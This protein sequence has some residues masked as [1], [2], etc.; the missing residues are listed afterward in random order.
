MKNKLL[1]ILLLA[2]A[3]KN[4]VAQQSWALKPY[5]ITLPRVTTTQQTNPA[6]VTQQAGNMVYNTDQQAVAVNN[7]GSWQYLGAGDT[8]EFK[9]F[10]AF[11]DYSPVVWS[12]PQGVTRF[13]IEA[14]GGGGGGDIYQKFLPTS[15]GFLSCNGGFSGAYVRKIV[16][17]GST[18]TS[19]TISV[20]YGGRGA[21]GNFLDPK[22]NATSGGSSIVQAGSF[23][24]V[25]TGGYIWNSSGAPYGSDNFPG[26]RALIIKGN[27]PKG[28]EMT[29]GQVS[30]TEF[31]KVIKGGCGGTA[32]GVAPNTGG[33][34]RTFSI[35]AAATSTATIY[36]TLFEFESGGV[37]LSYGSDPGGGG[38]CDFYNAGNGAPGLVIIRW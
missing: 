22:F 17:T 29:Y 33:F 16:D 3:G 4:S 7:G 36:N 25:A 15:G 38:G 26:N 19:L 30:S 10:A 8:G 12:V 9:N 34:G 31:V 37:D 2:M 21:Y 20:G 27:P 1:L 23:T 24:L 14:W 32:F 18:L 35:K 5:A 28:M 13:M 11:R 6:T